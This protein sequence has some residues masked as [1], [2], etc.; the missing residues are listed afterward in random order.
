MSEQNTPSQTALLAPTD[1]A[2]C[3]W[4]LPEEIALLNHLIECHAAAGDGSSFTGTTFA[5]ACPLVNALRKKGALKTAKACHNKFNTAIK[6]K[7]GWTWSDET[8]ASITPEMEPQW[9]AFLKANPKAK[10]FKNKGWVHL[11]KMT[12]LM[13]SKAKGTHVF[14]PSQGTT[15]LYVPEP[16]DATS[17]ANV[18]EGEGSNNGAGD[19]EEMEGDVDV[20]SQPSQPMVIPSTPSRASRKRERAVSETPA[21][22][23]KRVKLNAASAIQGLT[24]SIDRFGD[25]MCKVL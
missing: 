6:S 7:S 14:C 18:H 10:P 25:N 9:A 24:Q 13:P 8:G 12:R 1:G 21:A 4:T 23:T 16:A 11:E 20:P 15:G 5:G 17:S 19:G 2:K 22:S 3:H